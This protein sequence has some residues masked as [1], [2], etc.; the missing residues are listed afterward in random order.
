MDE[1][2]K[3]DSDLY[4]WKR[5]ESYQKAKV[6]SVIAYRYPLS[7]SYSCNSMLHVLPNKIS[8]TIE[9][10]NLFP[11]SSYFYYLL[12]VN[13]FSGCSHSLDYS[14][15]PVFRV[16]QGSTVDDYNVAAVKIY[17]HLPHISITYLM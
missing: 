15:H 4:L 17:F 5:K 16:S 11:S 7:Y 3:L 14:F 10:K 8:V 12:D 9:I 1:Y 13:I 6:V 2:K